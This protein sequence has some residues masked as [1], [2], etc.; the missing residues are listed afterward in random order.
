MAAP[1]EAQVRGFDW[2][3]APGYVA[4]PEPDELPV[5]KAGDHH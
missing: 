4:Q 2:F 5:I 3:R 1:A